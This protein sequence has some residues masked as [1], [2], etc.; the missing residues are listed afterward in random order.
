MWADSADFSLTSAPPAGRSFLY[1]LSIA[2]RVGY[3]RIHDN[4]R[5]IQLY[6]R[7]N[8][9]SLYLERGLIFA[10]FN[11]LQ[12]YPSSIFTALSFAG[13]YLIR[14]QRKKAGKAPAAYQA[15]HVA[16]LFST[17]INIMYAF[18]LR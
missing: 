3:L 2:S 10:P 14:S 12:S 13:L 1:L 7:V 17:A 9:I 11:S 15:W 6:H 18:L 16:I 8:L 4:R 5:C